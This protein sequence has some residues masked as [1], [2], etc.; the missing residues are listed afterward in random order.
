MM[1]RLLVAAGV[2]S[3]SGGLYGLTG[4]GWFLS[5][6]ILACAVLVHPEPGK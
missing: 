6:A 5:A 3:V 2:A 4:L 1:R